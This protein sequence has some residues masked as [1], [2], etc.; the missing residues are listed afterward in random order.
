MKHWFLPD[1]PDL[2]GLLREQAR[3]TQ[4]GLQQFVAW[5]DGD[6]TAA[7]LVRDTE[8]AADTAK[9]ALRTALRN[10]FS[11]P[12][13]PEDL[14]ELSERTDA[15]LNSAKNIVREAEV[16]AAP[17]DAHM[18]AMA[19]SIA[20]GHAHLCVAFDALGHEG[21][22]ATNAS[23]AA[24]SCCKDVERTY[25]AAMSELLA[26]DDVRQVISHRELYRRFARTADAVEQV[27]E[28]VW[29]AVVKSP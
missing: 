4:H 24:V 25:R 16:I 21:D 29:Y 27:A 18:A 9:R 1:M 20:E 6:A 5:A 17:P 15:V 22:A 13:D 2:L 10:A 14:Y 11:T 19:R 28:R 26:L 3:V 23:D 8:H 12:L 7:Q